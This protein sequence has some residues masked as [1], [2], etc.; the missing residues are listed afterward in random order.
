MWR[1]YFVDKEAPAEVRDFLRRYYM[2]YSGPGGMTE[3]DDMENWAYASQASEGQTARR[4]PYH[5]KAGLAAGGPHETVPGLRDRKADHQRAK[6]ACALSPLGRV[7]GC[8]K[9]GRTA[10]LMPAMSQATQSQSRLDELFLK[11]EVED[12]LYLEADLLDTRQYEAWLDLFTDDVRYWMPL[13][14]NVP[15]RER[16]E[17]SS[18]DDEVGWF[19]DDKETLTKRVKQLLTGIHWAEEPISRVSHFVSNVRIAG[20]R[21]IPRRFPGNL[22]HSGLSQSDGDGD[23]LSGRA[24]RGFVTARRRCAQGRQAQ[25]PH[26]TERL[27]GEESD[28]IPLFDI[29]SLMS[30]GRRRARVTTI[31][32]EYM[33]K[34][35]RGVL[36]FAAAA[37]G[38]VPAF[39]GDT[40]KIG[41]IG[42]YSG[43]YADLGTHMQNGI[44]LYVK[45]H[46]DK[47]A[48]TKIELLFR[49]DN[50][51][52]PDVAKRLTQELATR[53]NVDVLTGYIST[54]S[55]MASAPVAAKAQKPMLIVQ[56]ATSGITEKSAYATRLSYTLGQVAAP[57][58]NWAVK[59][60]IKTVF[61]LV[62]DFGPGYNAL[63]AF[64]KSFTAGGGQVA[65]GVKVPLG[66]LEFGPSCNGPATPRRRPFSSSFPPARPR[67]R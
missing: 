3:Q 43:L 31:G 66:N 13:R 51:G 57:L 32:R 45:L 67:R 42:P 40:I 25:N 14:K 34:S 39:A 48:G 33:K 63:A 55:A 29:F 23:R 56:A 9:L 54:P 18:R 6:S 47:I 28:R 49:D 11:N 4:Y 17:D 58:G 26:R 53:D 64:T 5:Y 10:N 36:A 38:A 12:L 65:G 59:N 27:D 60:G 50:N 7:H 8:A 2:R 41:V 52:S 46:G 20:L 61:T 37:L 22:P 15:W 24:T 1:V 62:T 44:N 19:D 16:D 35:I 30:T 21:Q